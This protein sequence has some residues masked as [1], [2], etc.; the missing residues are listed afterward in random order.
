MSVGV[1]R[2][3]IYRYFRDKDELY[4]EIMRRAR[5]ELDAA[6]I[7]AVDPEDSPVDQLR[8]GLAAYFTFVRNKGQEWELLFGGGTAIAGAVAVDAAQMRFET[9]EMIAT[10]V[11]A[12]ADH[13]DPTAV[14]A[15]AHAISGA[16]EQLAKWWRHHPE[17]TLEQIVAYHLEL[18]WQGLEQVVGGTGAPS[19]AAPRQH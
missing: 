12:A 2:P 5:A 11:Q 7:G 14:R 9:A 6:L 13:L 1:T 17:V 4:R 19:F 3:L 18:V 8:A 10:L 15:Y 16:A